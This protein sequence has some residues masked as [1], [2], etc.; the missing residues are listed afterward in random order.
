MILGNEL[1]TGQHIVLGMFTPD[2][3]VLFNDALLDEVFL[4]TLPGGAFRLFTHTEWYEKA[5][6]PLSFE[7]GIYQQSDKQLIG[8]AG[9][10]DLNWHARHASLFLAFADVG[11]W[12]NGFAVDAIQVLLRF[13]FMDTNLRRLYQYVPEDNPLL[14]NALHTANF[15]DEGHLRAFIYR[16]EKLHD[17]VVMGILRDEWRDVL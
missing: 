11:H 16:D 5:I 4:M 7:M 2:D 1:I 17:V 13:A 6:K 8:V 12:S 3:S 15:V 10:G 14:L 9:F